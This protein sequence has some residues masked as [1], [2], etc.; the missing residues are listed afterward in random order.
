MR[1]L[2]LVSIVLHIVLF[3][4]TMYKKIGKFTFRFSVL[5]ALLTNYKGFST[6][7]EA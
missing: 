4:T 7:I 1:R 2:Q 5:T 3:G 6:Q